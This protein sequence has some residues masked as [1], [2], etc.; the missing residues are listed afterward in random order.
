MIFETFITVIALA[1]I[2]VFSIHKFSRNIELVAGPNLKIILQKITSNPILGALTGAGI[3][4]V[5]QSSTATTVMTVG[6]VDA[7]LIT[8]YQSLGVIFGSNVGSTI[9]SQLIALNVTILAPFV[10]ILG[11]IIL[12]FGGVFKKYGKSVFYFGLVFL[13]ISL[14]TK[15]VT[16]L[17][18][19]QV[20]IDA[21]SHIHGL[22]LSILVG[23]VLT[24]LFQSSAITTGLSIV[25]AGSGLLDVSQGMGIMLGSNIGTASTAI[26]ASIPMSIEAKK[27]ALAHFMFN[28]LGLGLILAVFPL[29]LRFVESFGS[30]LSQ[31]I[32]NMHVI[33]NVLSATVFLIFI[34]QFHWLVL[35]IAKLPLLH[36]NVAKWEPKI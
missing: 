9:T 10:V 16:P 1:L 21:L 3:T 17:A 11:F 22:P 28:V 32:A 12:E 23:I 33:F 35:Q 8:F 14:I 2:F 5:V 15:I 6:L 7:G 36:F 29:C 30:P 24:I 26:L 31:Q 34:K 19:N 18:D 4:S 25:L 20:V 13:C 27:V